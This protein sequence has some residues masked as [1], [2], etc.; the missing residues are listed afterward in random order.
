MSLDVP[1]FAAVAAASIALCCGC[2]DRWSVATDQPIPYFEDTAAADAA[3]SASVSTRLDSAENPPAQPEDAATSLTSL[4]NAGHESRD[5]GCPVAPYA[6]VT[7][8]TVTAA[9]G[10][11]RLRVS[12]ESAD[13]GCSQ[14]ADWWEILGTDGALLYR[15]VLTHSHTDEN[16][17]TDVGAPGNTFTRDG[18]PVA[19]ETSTV[20][21]VRAH[22][23]RG[24]YH[25][26]V[27]RGSADS[28]FAPATD[29]PA[30]FASDV[31]RL[32]PQPTGCS[33]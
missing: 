16:G 3:V 17:T 31:E 26:Q 32:A 15:R 10:A 1:R 9:A 6:N 21:L 18:G 2:S 8:V 25:G 24:G 29:L 27:M 30:G 12:I 28:G 23:S 11:L 14:F 22:M 19:I 33:F 4:P 20:V 5:G 13:V 7:A